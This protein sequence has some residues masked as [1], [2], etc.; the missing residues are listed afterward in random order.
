[1]PNVVELIAT[2]LKREGVRH[3]F[4]IPGGGGAIDLLNATQQ[5]GIGF[6]L[7][8]HETA[9]AMMACAAGKLTGIPGVVI[10][11]IAWPAS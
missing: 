5:E 11:A 1:M 8:T 4:G 6:V 2:T 3:I 7:T 9:A 10:T